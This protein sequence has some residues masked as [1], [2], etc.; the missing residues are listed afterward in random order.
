MLVLFD[1][2]IEKDNFRAPYLKMVN[3]LDSR[4]LA[5]VI[6][7]LLVGHAKD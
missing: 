4:A 7:V 1:I 5:V 2:W 6:D 3:D